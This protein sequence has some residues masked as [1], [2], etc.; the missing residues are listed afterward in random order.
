MKE[1]H[2]SFGLVFFRV[3]VLLSKIPF[4]HHFYCV[5]NRILCQIKA[6]MSQIYF[7]KKISSFPEYN[8]CQKLSFAMKSAYKIVSEDHS[9]ISMLLT[10]QVCSGFLSRVL[11]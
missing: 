5:S 4:E 3:R 6:G 9:E 2:A 11:P 10:C 7:R 8:K 1:L